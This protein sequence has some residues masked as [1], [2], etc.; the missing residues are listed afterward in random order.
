M[1]FQAVSTANQYQEKGPSPDLVADWLAAIGDR[2]DRESFASLFENF[3]P[4]IKSYMMR[5]GAESALAEDLAQET[6]VKIWNKA[7]T[8]DRNKAVPAAWIFRIARNLRID[9]LRRQKFLEVEY[10][11]QIAEYRDD[12]ATESIN[13]GQ[14]DAMRLSAHIET[15]PDNQVQVIRLAFYEGLSHSEICER[16][17]LPLGTVKSR[18]RLAFAKLRKALD[19]ER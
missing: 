19:D 15:L 2:Q 7:N 8:Y 4:R 11:Q 10:D 5:L 16:L 17:E 12:N 13:T 6:M 9:K 14:I 18:L 1:T 3:A